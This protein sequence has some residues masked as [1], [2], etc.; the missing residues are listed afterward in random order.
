M[1]TTTLK[2]DWDDDTIG[3]VRVACLA[4]AEVLVSKGHLPGDWNRKDAAR[5]RTAA[6]DISSYV[7]S[8]DLAKQFLAVDELLGRSA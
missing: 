3:M 8:R 5:L 7:E 2:L 4:V 1:S 6:A